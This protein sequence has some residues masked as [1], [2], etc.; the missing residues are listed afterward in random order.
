M[1]FRRRLTFFGRGAN[2][3]DF[4]DWYTDAR[5]AQQYLTGTNPTTITNVSTSFLQEF[6]DAAKEQNLKD[7]VEILADGNKSNLYITDCSYFRNALGIKPSQHI[8]VQPK[9]KDDPARYGCATLTLFRLHD[10]GNLH[11]LAIVIDYKGSMKDSVC[12]FNKRLTATDPTVGEYW[13]KSS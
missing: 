2:I 1:R 4:S 9:D 11:P 13:R 3:G 7:V 6:R 5:F 12:L 10:D 8:K